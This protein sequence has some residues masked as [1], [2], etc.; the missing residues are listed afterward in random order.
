MKD[1]DSASSDVVRANVEIVGRNKTHVFLK[2][3]AL[4]PTRIFVHPQESLPNGFR[5]AS[6]LLADVKPATADFVS[7]HYTVE[8]EY[9]A[10]VSDR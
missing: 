6:T 5:G 7:D 2:I 10:I 4:F 9:H 8:L 3:P 1:L